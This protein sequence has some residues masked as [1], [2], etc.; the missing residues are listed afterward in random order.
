[1][2]KITI[3]GSGNIGLSLAKGLVNKAYCKAENI[4]L[5]RRNIKL[6]TEEVAAGF[7]VSDD[8]LAAIEGAD[9]V[10]LGVLPQQLKKVLVQL[11]AIWL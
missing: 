10:V 4:T 7:K 6:M 1:M 11:Q 2:K 5:T 9:I 3:I 8:N